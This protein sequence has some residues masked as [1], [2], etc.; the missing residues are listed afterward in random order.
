M[1]PVAESVGV[2]QASAEAAFNWEEPLLLTS[3][4][5]DEE[6]LVLESARSFCQA[7]L[8]PR[9]RDMHRHEAFDPGI[10]RQF[11]ELGFLGSTLPEQY[12]GGG[13][14]YVSYGLIAREVERVDSGFRSA[15]ILR[16]GLRCRRRRWDA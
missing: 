8:Q 4:L 5:S 11:G 7:Q 13:L 15:D 14:N 3:Q 6:R 9:V 12:G 10:M 1:R 16:A 2:P